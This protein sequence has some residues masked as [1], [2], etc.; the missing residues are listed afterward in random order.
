MR[1]E[2]IEWLEDQ[3]TDTKQIDG[4]VT[5]LLTKINDLVKIS[6]ISNSGEHTAYRYA[7]ALT[8]YDSF[9]EI[10]D[11]ILDEEVGTPL[12][13]KIHGE[14]GETSSKS[15]NKQVTDR[16]SQAF[17]VDVES[18]LKAKGWEVTGNLFEAKEEYSKSEL[19]RILSIN[20][21]TGKEF[22]ADDITSDNI[23]KFND[24]WKPIFQKNPNFNPYGD[25][26]EMDEVDVFDDFMDLIVSLSKDN[27]K[28]N[29]FESKGKNG[30]EDLS[31]TKK[32]KLKKLK[33]KLNECLISDL[34]VTEEERSGFL[35]TLNLV[36]SILERK[37]E[38]EMESISIIDTDV[39]GIEDLLQEVG[40]NEIAVVK[41]NGEEVKSD[42]EGKIIDILGTPVA[43]MDK[44]VLDTIP[45]MESSTSKTKTFVKHSH[46]LSAIK[47]DIAQNK[48]LNQNPKAMLDWVKDVI[49]NV[50]T[51]G[52]PDLSD[53]LYRIFLDDK[54]SKSVVNLYKKNNAISMQ[55]REYLSWVI[56]RI[57]KNPFDLSFYD[58]S[59]IYV[60]TE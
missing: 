38:Q 47:K 12:L 17:G 7:T 32:T 27:P 22:T 39:D 11:T 4:D 2:I 3:N 14:I 6:I 25:D 26:I 50:K 15:V 57:C 55:E 56:F 42:I 13:N 60:E 31:E 49:N 34:L 24:G 20:S 58:E 23:K 30:I 28:I 44:S 10:Y 19:A 40:E 43:V 48:I 29:L 37:K 45:L 53:F 18:L 21:T 16:L 35:S 5:V 33:T 36:N 54:F 8:E 41:I 46:V 9:K 59:K 51:V 1:T 52:C